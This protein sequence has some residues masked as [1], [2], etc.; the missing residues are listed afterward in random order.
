MYLLCMY[1][2]CL[3]YLKT[4][5]YMDLGCLVCIFERTMD[6]LFIFL[7]RYLEYLKIVVRINSA[8]IA[9]KKAR[10]IEENGL[11]QEL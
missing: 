11:S 1:Y 10:F 6:S 9:D 5:V 2:V 8:N 4:L 3:I 7:L